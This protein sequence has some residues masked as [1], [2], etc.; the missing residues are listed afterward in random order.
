VWITSEDSVVQLL[1][2]NNLPVHLKRSLSGIW[3]MLRAKYYIFNSSLCDISAWFS[4]GARTVNLWHGIPLKKINFDCKTGLWSK[5][6]N[7][8]SIADYIVKNK[9]TDPSF[10]AYPNVV[11]APSDEVAGKLA[12]ALRATPERCIISRYPR[13]LPFEWSR[14]HNLEM[15]KKFEEEEVAK[16]VEGFKN[17]KKVFIYLPTF[18]D[19]G[20][21]G[22]E[23]SGID[24]WDLNNQLKEN[25]YLM[26]IKLHHF[27]NM[28]PS[29]F[30]GLDSVILL[31]SDVDIYPILPFTD[32][33]IT[34]YSSVYFDYIYL[35]REII[36][37]PFDLSEY[38]SD[39]GLYYDYDKVTPGLKV[40]DYKSLL[41][42][43]HSIDEID[44]A[45][46]RKRIKEVFL[47]DQFYLD[48]IIDI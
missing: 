27:V 6:F 32:V 41:R 39:R 13:T 35:N 15:I 2:R 25:N 12:S 29:L 19:S 45:K 17:Y 8:K 22:F 10:F 5:R 28:D 26:V 24:L 18:R 21:N 44:Y 47:S 48:R 23:D 11:L 33:L 42:A 9:L 46:E 7:R 4:G 37:F 1:R 30:D 14:E 38:M 20:R 16:K 3:Y 31:G 43:I 36:F 40:Y 34:D